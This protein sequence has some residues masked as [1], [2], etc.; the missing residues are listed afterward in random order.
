MIAIIFA[1]LLGTVFY[2]NTN[3]IKNSYKDIVK[4]QA[5]YI[6]EAGNARAVAMMNVKNLPEVYF[7][8]NDDDDEFDDEF[9]DDWEDFDDDDFD[10]FD[11]DFDDEED[12]DEYAL[13]KVPDTSTS[14]NVS[15]T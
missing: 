11:E 5:Q 4:L 7:D 3:N 12:I 9:D 6:A 10:E 14:I 13:A 2:F 1:G 8:E 15:P